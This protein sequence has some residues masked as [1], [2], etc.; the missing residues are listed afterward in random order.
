MDYDNILGNNIA[1]R[2]KNATTSIMVNAYVMQQA[3]LYELTT[4]KYYTMSDYLIN[5]FSDFTNVTALTVFDDFM[6]VA[7][8]AFDY[9]FFQAPYVSSQ[10]QS[11]RW[12][13]NEGTGYFSLQTQYKVNKQDAY[14]LCLC[15]F[16]PIIWW[17]VVWLISLKKNGGVARGSSQIALL[18]AGMTPVAQQTLRGFSNLDSSNAFKRAQTMR[19]RLGRHN[20]QVA[21]GMENENNL[22]PLNKL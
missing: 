14:V 17:F 10:F 19:I 8:P 3:I 11:L 12:M 5:Y 22:G 6:K 13:V 18:T 9:A 2:A 21:F 4:P 7:L 1:L 20:N 15:L 16:L